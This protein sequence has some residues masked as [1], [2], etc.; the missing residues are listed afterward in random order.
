M[1]S[2]ERVLAALRRE[3]P[4]RVPYLEIGIDR[5]LAVR[6][7]GWPEDDPPAALDATPRPY[8]AAEY[9]ELA[10]IL[11]LDN[12]CYSLRPPV[13]AEALVGGGGRTYSGQGFIRS[14]ADLRLVQLPDPHD[15]ALYG[16]AW[17][18]LRHK[19][20]YA[21]CF[22]TRIGIFNVM[23]SLGLERFCLALYDQPRLVELLLDWYTTWAAAVAERV[24]AMGFDVFIST[25]DMAFNI[26][27]YFSPDVFRRLVAPYHRRVAE[28]ITLPWIMHS[29]GNLLPLVEDILDLGISGLHPI[30]K[31]A[32]DIRAFKRQYG[33]RVCVLGNVDLNI[34]GMGTPAQVEDEVRGLIR[35]V[36]PGGGYMVTSGNSLAS[37]V[38]PENAVALGAAVHK[39]G[40]YPITPCR[41]A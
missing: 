27:P 40:R 3:T 31:G 21:A 4:D 24:C 5:A 15:D 29:D 22:V 32:M 30:E 7:G 19:G 11:H 36:A 41:P 18:F 23:L 28:K 25:D 9:R 1:N 2:R 17:E 35:D 6:L 39:Y 20:D 14:E 37:Y 16:E 38:R 10:R 34:L 13:Y 33:G 8:T 26:A 12:M